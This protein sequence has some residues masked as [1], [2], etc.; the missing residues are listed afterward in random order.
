MSSVDAENDVFAVR[1]RD[2]EIYLGVD[3]GRR[4]PSPALAVNV[5]GTPLKSPAR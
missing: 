4:V 1:S 2:A 5:A 3:I